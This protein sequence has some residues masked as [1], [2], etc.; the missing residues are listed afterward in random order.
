MKKKLNFENLGK[1]HFIGAGGIFMSALI[2]YCL[3][4]GKKVSGSDK[5]KSDMTKE[6]SRL[7][8][9]IYIGHSE[10]N[11][12]SADAVVYSS[13]VETDN[14]EI[15]KAEK[16]KIPILK[17]SEFLA[18]IL[19]GY[20]NVIAV[21]GC[22]GKTTTTAMIAHA[23]LCA[24]KAPTAFIGGRDYKF[25]NF[26]SG[27][28]MYAVSEACEYKKNFLDI[29]PSVAVI[30]NIDNDHIES[31]NGKSDLIN[32]FS[33]FIKPSVA[34]INADD[35]NCKAVIRDGCIT[36]GIDSP[37]F[38]RA[39]NVRRGEGGYSFILSV[40]GEK[41]FKVK[42]N[43][44]GK[45]NVYNALATFAACFALKTDLSAA[46]EA[47]E[48]FSPVE[49][50]TE[51]LGEFSG[52]KIYAD[53]A[54]HPNEIKEVLSVFPKDCL[55]V[56]QPHTY[57]RTK[58]LKNEFTNVLKTRNTVIYKTYPARE[59]YQKEGDG[60]SLYLCLKKNS[61][62]ETY[63]AKNKTAL[64]KIIRESSAETVAFIGAGDIY[65]TAKKFFIDKKT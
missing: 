37:A 10:S 57:S 61:P 36:Y 23:L 2:K 56:F 47:L 19:E 20:E 65:F 46:A 13:A 34:V 58:Y 38:I 42:L 8:A 18:V 40:N 63:Y 52:K 64:L 6:L 39:E 44:L 33:Q 48:N 4:A 12:K 11:L 3:V 59:K 22:H 5:I 31:Y 41:K 60:Y 28:K 35:A 43:M 17:R 53:Y 62:N 7:G 16:L 55:I 32:S 30:T 51:F 45:F 26:L 9:E 21:S 1:I 24:K 29:S 27:A 54:H 15:L 49:R 50:R 14:P 25:G